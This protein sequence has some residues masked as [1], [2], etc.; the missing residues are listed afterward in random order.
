LDVINLVFGLSLSCPPATNNVNVT[1]IAGSQFYS[2][3]DVIDEDAEPEDT[4][5]M[6][7]LPRGLQFKISPHSPI[8][9]ITGTASPQDAGNTYTWSITYD[10][11]YCEWTYFY[12]FTIL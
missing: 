3:V 1:L 5:G 12:T 6:G 9:S 2:E 10:D 11:G 7:T 4:N 8:E